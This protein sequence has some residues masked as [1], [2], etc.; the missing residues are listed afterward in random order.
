MRKILITVDENSMTTTD[1]I[2]FA[3]AECLAES[4]RFH[5]LLAQ[6]FGVQIETTRKTAKPELLSALTNVQEQTPL[7]EHIPELGTEG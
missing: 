4:Q 5:D 2:N 1:Y 3:G 7:Q 6:Q